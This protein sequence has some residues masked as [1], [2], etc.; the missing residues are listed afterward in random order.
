MAEKSSITGKR[1]RLDAID[2]ELKVKN[3]MIGYLSIKGRNIST[4]DEELVM[5]RLTS[6]FLEKLAKVSFLMLPTGN[7]G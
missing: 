4:N 2:D 7:P 3:L 5:L 1:K 6:W